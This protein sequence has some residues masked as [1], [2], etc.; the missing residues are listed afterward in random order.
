MAQKI[1][2]ILRTLLKRINGMLLSMP[3]QDGAP[4]STCSKK[5]RILMQAMLALVAIIIFVATLQPAMA[6]QF[7]PPSL[8]G[9]NLH[10][11][12][13]AD[14][15]GDEV[16][17]THIRQYLNATGD[18]I[19]SMSSGGRVW[20]WSLDMRDSETGESN[21]VIRDS[22]CDGRFDELYGLDEE[23]H[24]PACVK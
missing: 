11:E 7:E 22:D 10:A 21:Y 5:I 18:S 16:N 1:I 15:D 14:G 8:Q 20:A 9:Y 4:D 6:G 19:V 3:G 23:F 24:V 12:R 17:E 13:D 2:M